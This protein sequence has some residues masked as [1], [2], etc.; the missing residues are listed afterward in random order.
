MAAKP[1]F[2]VLYDFEAQMGRKLPQCKEN[3]IL[4][5][6]FCRQSR[7]KQDAILNPFYSGIY[8]V[9]YQH[10][11]FFFFHREKLP[12]SSK[13]I[14]TRQCPKVALIYGQNTN[15]LKQFRENIVNLHRVLCSQRLDTI[16]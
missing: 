8:S 2:S 7:Q 16:G 12:N 14:L 11:G 13:M 3:K 15:Y 5:L 10:K 4:Q 9:Q 1:R 6:H